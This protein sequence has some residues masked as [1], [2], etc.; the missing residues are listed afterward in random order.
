MFN[1]FV[2]EKLTQNKLGVLLICTLIGPFYLEPE[3][4]TFFIRY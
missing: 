2:K 4:M 3:F 1:F